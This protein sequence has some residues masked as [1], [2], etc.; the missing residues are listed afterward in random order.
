MNM[1]DTRYLEWEKGVSKFAYEKAEEYIQDYKDGVKSI[2][3]KTTRGKT[4][5]E[6]MLMKV[7]HLL[8]CN[9]IFLGIDVKKRKDKIYV[10]LDLH[11]L[12]T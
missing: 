6:Y 4:P 8:H 9:G 7:W 5:E 2:T 11:P 10:A 12:T 1:N 3:Y